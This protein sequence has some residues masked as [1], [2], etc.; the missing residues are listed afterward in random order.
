VT[1]TIPEQAVLTCRDR[2]ILR[3]VAAGTAELSGGMHPDLFLEGR[4]CCDQLAAHRLVESGLIASSV[5]AGPCLRVP[6]RL[7]AAG[8]AALGQPDPS[9]PRLQ[10]ARLGPTAGRQDLRQDRPYAQHTRR[11]AP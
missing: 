6:A 5:A 9:A 10:A 11:A 8:Q 2:A 4:C 7:T 3:A 1:A